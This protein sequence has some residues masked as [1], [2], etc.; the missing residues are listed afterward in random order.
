MAIPLGTP[1]GRYAL[2]LS[3]YSAQQQQGL[4]IHDESGSHGE[5]IVLTEIDLTRPTTLVIDEIDWQIGQPLTGTNEVWIENNRL[6]GYSLPE[7]S[8]LRAGEGFYISN[9]LSCLPLLDRQEATYRRTAHLA[10]K[11]A[12]WATQTDE[13]KKPSFRK[14]L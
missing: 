6:L 4:E 9:S 8:T 10:I 2:E 13:G 12:I 7:V 11:M 5:W 14:R 3:F 1:P